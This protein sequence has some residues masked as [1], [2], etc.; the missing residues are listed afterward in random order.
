METLTLVQ[1]GKRNPLPL[2]L[3]DDPQGTYWSHLIKFL[4]DELLSR[5]YVEPDRF[6]AFRARSVRPDEAVE[7]IKR[8][9]RRY[10]SLRYVNGQLVIRLTSQLPAAAVAGTAGWQFMDILAPGRRY[11][12]VGALAARSRR[13]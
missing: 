13:Q 1:T 7:K 8:F 2:V 5:K 11:R 9:Y 4:K 12:A 6:F 10:H 3:V